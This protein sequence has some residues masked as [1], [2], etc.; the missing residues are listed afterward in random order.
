MVSDL[1]RMGEWSPENVG[2]RWVQGDGSWVGSI[3]RGHN[4]SGLRRWS[5]TARVVETE[6]GKSF[7][8]A[9]TFA[10]FPVANW[11]YDFEDAAGGCRVIES[12]R[13]NRAPWQRVL[14]RVMGD[15]SASHARREMAATL[16]KLKAAAEKD[17]PD[18]SMTRPPAGG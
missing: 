8:I 16:A 6:P 5:T 13:D 17:S 11:R 7:E 3:F 12:W 1:P 2:G 10:R 15:H 14:G 4:R 18:H 9:I